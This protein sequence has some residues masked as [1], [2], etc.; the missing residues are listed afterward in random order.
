MR[1]RSSERSRLSVPARIE[2]AL[3]ALG[4]GG[5]VAAPGFMQ[6]EGV[7]VFHVAGN[8]GLKRT[9]DKDDEPK[10][11]AQPASD[12]REGQIDAEGGNSRPNQG[13]RP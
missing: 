10:S 6:P 9:L 2:G 3:L 11:R 13:P 1:S 12:T 7:I 8:F 5:S 4:A